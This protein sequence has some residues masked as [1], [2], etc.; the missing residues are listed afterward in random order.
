M[1][2]NCY[3]YSKKYD[4]INQQDIDE[5]NNNPL[6]NFDQ[7]DNSFDLTKTNSVSITDNK[8]DYYQEIQLPHTKTINENLTY[9]LKFFISLINKSYP[10]DLSQTILSSADYT[11][12]SIIILSFI[13]IF[14]FL[15]MIII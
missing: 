1:I 13:I 10:Q 4:I 14:L 12:A 15:I 2:N 3:N 5:I 7:I 8:N 6:I 9:S 11:F